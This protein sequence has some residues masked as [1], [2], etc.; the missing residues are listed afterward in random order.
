MTTALPR[1]LN[2][3]GI[4][5]PDIEAAIR[6]YEEVLGYCVFA[7]P[8]ELSLETDSHGQLRD[9]LGPPFRRL[10]IAHL[11][12]GSGCGI[13]LFESIHP[14]HQR[15]EEDVEF[16]RSGTFHFC[17]TDPDIEGL[18]AKITATGGRQLS[19][20]WDDRPPLGVFRMAYC[21]DP[22]GTLIEVHTHSYEIVQGWR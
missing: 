10:K 12:S 15:R 13:E 7:G 16:Y 1:P 9:V 18:V 17:V 3:I 6:W 22:W 19:Q 2:H 5:V 14:P 11:S 8:V 21:Q 4:G 20:I